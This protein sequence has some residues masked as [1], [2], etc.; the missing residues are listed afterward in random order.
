[1]RFRAKIKNSTTPDAST[2]DAKNT[3]P[4]GSVA[5]TET[6]NRMIDGMPINVLMCDPVEARIIYANQTSIDTLRPLEG[7]LP[8]KAEDLIGQCIDIFHK[9]PSHQRKL[10]ADPG[11]LPHRAKIRLGEEILDLRVSAVMGGNGD[12]LGPMVTWSLVTKQEELADN[13]ESGVMSIVETVTSA[14]KQMQSAAQA[15]TANA[16]S[17]R[18]ESQSVAAAAEQASTNVQTVA[19][20]TEELSSTIQEVGRQVTQS[21]EIATSAVKEAEATNANFE[22]LA[23][24]SATIGDVINLINDIASQTNLLALNATIEAA[25]A[26]EAGKGFAVVASEVKSLATQTAKATDD[27]AN[28]ISQMQAATES[29]VRAI[30][31]IGDTITE[32]SDITTAIAVSVEDQDVATREISSNIQQAASGTKEVSASI[33]NVTNA[34]TETGTAAAEVLAGAQSLSEQSETLKEQVGTFLKE[35][36]AM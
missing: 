16:N 11:N 24:A 7:L 14:A 8:C 2:Q 4:G 32:I 30:K 20:A 17:T 25:R 23:K 12:Y 13:F 5:D 28:Q 35:V 31:G 21:T 34:A 9:N 6:L 22:E 19:A 36:R 3:D 29:S 26:G 10:L 27:I 1:M 15:M 18:E 33:V